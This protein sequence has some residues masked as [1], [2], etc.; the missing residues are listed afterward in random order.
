MSGID[1]RNIFENGRHLTRADAINS[2]KS[3]LQLLIGGLRRV[4]GSVTG[5]IRCESG[6]KARI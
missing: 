6:E 2:T 5:D 4:I 3:A 1:V